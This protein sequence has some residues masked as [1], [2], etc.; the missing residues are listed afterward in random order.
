MA[1]LFVVLVVNSCLVFDSLRDEVH[2]FEKLEVEV[3][4]PLVVECPLHDSTE[5]AR[6]LLRA[7]EPFSF[8]SRVL[9]VLFCDR[10]VESVVS[11]Q[12]FRPTLESSGFT[13][14]LRTYLC[15]T[16]LVYL[17]DDLG[18]RLV[19]QVLAEPGQLSRWLLAHHPVVEVDLNH[20]VV[21]LLQTFEDLVQWRLPQE[22]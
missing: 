16:Q 17:F 3:A 14:V 6:P 15:L 18:N 10:V 13:P 11:D 5:P 20:S 22:R 21:A 9:L 4:L 19:L 12:F 1:G 7:Q 8:F 2:H